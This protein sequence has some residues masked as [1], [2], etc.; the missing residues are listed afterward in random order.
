MQLKGI[1]PH[2]IDAFGK[3]T[4]VSDENIKILIS[5]MGFDA[6]D[7]AS[8]ASYYLEEE[9]QHWLSLLPAVSVL[10]KT[11]T[12]LL[13]VHLPIDFVTDS[14]IYRITAEN[15]EQLD[16]TITA[17]DFPLIGCHLIADVEFQLYEIRLDIPFD[18]GYHQLALLEQGNEEPLAEM[19]LIITPSSC[20]KPHV[21]EEGK[22]LWG[23]SVQLYCLKSESNWGIGDFSDLKQLLTKTAENGGDFIGLNPIHALY[24]A[25]PRN[26]S[27]YSPSSR[28]WLNILYTD[29]TAVPEFNHCAE[30]KQQYESTAFQQRLSA[31]RQVEWVDYSEV[32]DVKLSALRVLFST[33]NNGQIENAARLSAFNDFIVQKGEPLQ[34]Q[35][36]Y[37]ALH[38]YFLAENK[39]AW[40]WPAWPE[41]FQSFASEGTTQWRVDNAQDIL[42]WCYCQWV[43]ETQL[44]E[45]D[46]L[47]KSL[48]MALGL[49]RDL[50]VGVSKGG[51]DIWANHDS[52]YENISIGAPPDVLGPLGQCWGLPPLSPEQLTKTGYQP[53][54]EL[55]QSNMS[56]CGALRIDHVLALLRL[57]WVPEGATAAEGAYIYYNVHDMLNILALESVR[58]QCLVIGEDLGTIPEGMDVLLKDAGVYS[59]KVF[60]FEQAHDGGFISPDHYIQQ[61]MATLSTHDI[62]TIKGYWHC[63]DL[64]LGRTLGLYPDPDVFDRLLQGRI[65]SKQQILN[66]LHGHH[67]LPDGLYQDANITGM[68]KTLNFALQVHLAKGSPSLLSLQLEDFLEMDQPVNVP[69]TSDEYKNWQRKLTRNVDEIFADQDIVHLLKALT[70]ARAN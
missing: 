11:T 56:H 54:I 12:Y 59:Y 50:A 9:N 15:G 53:F 34:Q 66:S 40:G 25:Q 42:F 26:A 19:S 21:I 44:E 49:Y 38:F 10:Q 16:L 37:D 58:N 18:I 32:T 45:A 39:E 63:E 31:L 22:K 55:L 61:S 24:P 51:S 5:R 7:E 6:S 13:E 57:W 20:F 64:Y 30:I 46:Q 69:G 70:D 52:Y 48:G 62:A 29:I 1:D 4:T 60:F 33:L 67:S 65:E 43:T 35:A 41:N 14:L 47:A 36:T 68:D 2:F 27:P 8:L 28:K 23:T 17:T 3:P